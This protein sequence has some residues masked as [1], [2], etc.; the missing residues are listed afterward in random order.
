M[1]HSRVQGGELA[2]GKGCCE[3]FWHVEGADGC[4]VDRAIQTGEKVEV[5]ILAGVQGESPIS[6]IVE[7]LKSDDNGMGPCALVIA[8]DI[9][10]LRRAETEVIAHKSFIASIADRTPDEIYALNAAGCITWMNE[11]AD[12]L[13]PVTIPG[14]G[15]LDILSAESRSIAQEN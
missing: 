12:A 11:R 5:E 4:V 10:D 7:P 9:S 14:G 15:F 6:I 1:Q 13:K 2:I 8:R 3:M